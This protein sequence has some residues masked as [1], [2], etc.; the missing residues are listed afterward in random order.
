MNEERK[1]TGSAQGML[2]QQPACP[3][4]PPCTVHSGDAGTKRKTG[5]I[6]C[7]GKPRRSRRCPAFA[8]ARGVVIRSMSKVIKSVMRIGLHAS[9]WRWHQWTRMRIRS[10]PMC[11]E[12]ASEDQAAVWWRAPGWTEDRNGLAGFSRRRADTTRSAR[13]SRSSRNR[14][15]RDSA[16]A[17]RTVATID[18]DSQ[19]AALWLG[20][21]TDDSPRRDGSEIVDA[22]C[23]DGRPRLTASVSKQ[24]RDRPRAAG[25]E[26][27]LLSARRDSDA[28]RHE[29]ADDELASEIVFFRIDHS[30]TCETLIDPPT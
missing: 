14:R 8:A 6:A 17:S 24:T 20:L 12:N 18:A 2:V 4:P 16:R 3:F 5:T 15:R 19:S 11:G 10:R 25:M 7:I 9:R 27:P 21:V 13:G 28:H 29:P 23:G 22:L 30:A 26:R 1:G